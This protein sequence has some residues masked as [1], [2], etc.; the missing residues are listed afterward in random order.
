MQNFYIFVGYLFKIHRITSDV[1]DICSWICFVGYPRIV[2]FGSII[3]PHTARM[4]MITLAPTYTAVSR[5][6]PAFIMLKDSLAKV[7]KVVKPPQ[8]PVTSSSFISGDSTPLLT[9][10]T[11]SPMS[12][13]PRILTANVPQ[14]NDVLMPESRY[15]NTDPAAPPSATNNR[16]LTIL[17]DLRCKA[18]ASRTQWNLFQLLRR[19]RVSRC[20]EI[21]PQRY[22]KVGKSWFIILCKNRT[23]LR[24]GD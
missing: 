7:L 11:N 8:N 23:I 14:G 13:E 20:D 17:S 21:T 6:S 16:F 12:N 5:T 9:K 24:F 10:P 2:M 1:T 15:R 3:P 22:T 18:R 4:P 19:S